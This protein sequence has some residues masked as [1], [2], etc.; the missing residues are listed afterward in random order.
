M[1]SSKSPIKNGRNRE[2]KN[3]IV[4]GL[5]LGLIVTSVVALP[6]L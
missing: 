2:L 5:E 6:L 3:R 1:D 4:K